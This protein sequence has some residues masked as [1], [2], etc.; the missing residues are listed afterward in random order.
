MRLTPL[1]TMLAMT[2]LGAG[3]VCAQDSAAARAALGGLLRSATP[4][5]LSGSGRAR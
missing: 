3:G 2:L 4:A 1:L 5:F